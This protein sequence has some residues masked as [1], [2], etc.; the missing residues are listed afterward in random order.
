MLQQAKSNFTPQE[1]LSTERDAKTKSEYI[2]G[3]LYAMAGASREHNLI[4]S[5]IVRILGNQLLERPCNVYT[6]D[7]KI[8]S[9]GLRAIF[10][11]ISSFLVKRKNL[12]MKKRMFF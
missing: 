9:N 10:T 1:Y 8:K 2:S 12:K 5:N 3:E 6:N 7:M 11:L 4:S